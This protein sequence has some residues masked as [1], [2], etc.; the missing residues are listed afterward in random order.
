MCPWAR[1]T[2]GHRP[3]P[4]ASS[5]TWHLRSTRARPAP[6]ARGA[7]HS[8]TPTALLPRRGT[9]AGPS[10]VSGR[11]ALLLGPG[12][13]HVVHHL[14]DLGFY[15]IN[16]SSKNGLEVGSLQSHAERPR[17]PPSP[18]QSAG[19]IFTL[20]VKARGSQVTV[21]PHVSLQDKGAQG[22]LLRELAPRRDPRTRQEEQGPRQAE[23]WGPLE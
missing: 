7:C 19:L 20:G 3:G 10:W 2:R 8:A 23:N 6:Q 16:F 5:S 17:C 18:S 12:K 9:G 21:L 13:P 22:R 14:A 4:W 11:R 1:R 15:R